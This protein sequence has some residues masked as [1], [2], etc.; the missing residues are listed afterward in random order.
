MTASF[1]EGAFAA[2]PG[3][4]AADLNVPCSWYGEGPGHVARVCGG[5]RQHVPVCLSACGCSWDDLDL[6]RGGLRWPWGAAGP[7][8]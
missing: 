4:D 3:W 7:G 8:V 6:C 2:L 1:Q 5:T